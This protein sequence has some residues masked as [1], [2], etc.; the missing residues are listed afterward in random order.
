[1]NKHKFFIF[2]Y[3]GWRNVGDDAMLY[4][5]LRELHASDPKANFAILARMPVVIPSQ[6]KSRT[7]FVKLSPLAVL[8]EVLKSSVV[9]I[10]GGTWMHDYG[11][12]VTNMRTLL[13]LFILALI[14]K[15]FNNKVYLIGHGLGPLTTVWGKIL[16]RLICQLGDAIST[17]DKSAYEILKVWGFRDKASVGFDLSALL[18]PLD[19][20]KS[21]RLEKVESDKQI[22]GISITPVFEIYHGQREKDI[23]LIDRIAEPLNKWLARDSR[24]EVYLF[25]FKG[26]SKDDDVQITALLQERLQPTERIKVV[27]YDPD[28]R[29]MLGQVAQCF[30]F[31]GTKYHSCLFAYISKIPLLVID[32]HPKC[33]ALANNIGLPKQAVISLEEVLNGQF[34]ERLENLV[35]SPKDFYATLPISLAKKMARDG[36]T[37][38]KLRG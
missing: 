15:V 5:L 29:S 26:K 9:I 27:H 18:E 21:S 30:A 16:A 38:L 34:Y 35:N 22:L 20:T 8:W 33:R 7:T 24:A 3:Y 23:L 37:K 19:E 13:I 11:K 17:R 36:I 2:G 10:G 25:V 12:R 31:L 6:V 14:A 1:M 4:A 32:Y 28:P